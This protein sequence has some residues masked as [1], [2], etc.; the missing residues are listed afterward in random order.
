MPYH[1]VKKGTKYCVYNKDTGENKGCSASEERAKAHMAALY[2]NE[3]SVGMLIYMTAA[4]PIRAVEGSPDRYRAYAVQFGGP[5]R[6][7]LYKQY[8]TKDT[9]FCLDWYTTR[10]WLYHHGLHPEMGAVKI[11]TWDTIGVD[12][13]GV[14][15]EGERAQHHKYSAAVDAL[16]A[17]N[18]L[19]PSSGALAYLVD[20]ADDGWV[21]RWPIAEVSSTVSPAEYRMEHISPVAQRAIEELNGGKPMNGLQKLFLKLADAVGDVDLNATAGDVDDAPDL[22]ALP[23]VDAN[24]AATDPIEPVATTE[25]TATLSVD[26]V[27]AAVLAAAPVTALTSTLDQVVKAIQLLDDQGKT[28]TATV[29]ALRSSVNA[30]AKTDAEKVAAV[31]A[32][33]S[34]FNQLHVASRDAADQVPGSSD[35][36]PITPGGKPLEPGE[37]VLSRL[38]PQ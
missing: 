17:E 36:P 5:N 21:K 30:M 23:A 3:K 11:G 24:A 26:D 34:W 32:S 12:E 6:R 28:T 8:F 9:D 20:V 7:D 13:E 22:D 15:I 27:V 18:I 33:G 19:Y 29:E 38:R 4:Q 31:L 25:P 37:S 1:I 14:F 16:L 35:A 10:P 2:A